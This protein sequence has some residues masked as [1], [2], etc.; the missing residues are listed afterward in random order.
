MFVV[1]WLERDNKGKYRILLFKNN[2]SFRI[3]NLTA[4]QVEQ[5]Y[6]LLRNLG[7][8]VFLKGTSEDLSSLR[9]S[10]QAKVPIDDRFKKFTPIWEVGDED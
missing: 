1:L 7:I 3:D 5:F 8:D 2:R 9:I 4:R 10:E 6:S